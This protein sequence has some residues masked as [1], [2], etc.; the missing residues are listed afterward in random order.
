MHRFYLAKKINGDTIVISD[1]EQLHHLRGVLRLKM[2]DEV[3]V[4]DDAGNEF[5]CRITGLS[6]SQAALRVHSKKTMQ[7]NK[8]KLTI[9]C[10]IPKMG[11]MDDIV[12]SLTQLGV[13]AIIPM[14][15]ERVVVSLD[16]GKREAKLE[17]WRK[18]ARSAAEQSQRNSIPRIEPVTSLETVI[19]QSQDYD[20]K[21][22]PALF[23]ERK[24]IKEVLTK[25]KAGNILV[26]VGPEGDFTP[27]EIELAKGAGF[28][29]VSMG[30]SVLRVATAAIAVASF[31]RLSLFS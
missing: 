31:I 26:L 7:S 8:V 27:E 6:K 29:P 2:N 15:T 4:F 18:I 23:D 30:D 1:A 9:A 16:G 24:P 10:A 21:L 22:I 28:I 25:S 3:A 12:D 11:K 5:T 14:Q 17:R 19:S 13:D 20:L